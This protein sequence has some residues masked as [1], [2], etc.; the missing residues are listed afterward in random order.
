[1][2]EESL[3]KTNFVGRDG[4]R[5]WIGQVA[6]ETAQGQQI[7]GAGW[8]NRYKVRI[9]G[10]HPYNTSELK[11]EDLPWAQVLLP[12]TSGSGGANQS[13]SVQLSP[14]DSVIGFFLD[15][16]SAQI[17]IIWGVFGR[18]NQVSQNQYQIPFLPYTGQ[19]S[20]TRHDG[21]NLNKGEANESNTKSQK[22]PRNVP[23]SL[24]KKIGKDEISFFSGIG[25]KIYFATQS[26]N[27]TIGKL[28]VEVDN[29]V[30]ALQ[31]GIRKVSDL[32]NVVSDKIQSI[33]TGLVGSM[34]NAIYEKLIPLLNQGLKLLYQ[35]VYNLVLAATGSSTAAHLAGVA[36]QTAMVPP[37][38]AIQKLL[39]CLA[40]SIIN[41]LL[42]TIT[43]LLKSVAKH[44]KRFSSCASNQ[45]AGSLINDIIERIDSG[46]SSVL[47]GVS[48]LLGLIGGFNPATF[49]R[50]AVSS[51][52][53][54]AGL[55]SCNQSATD[56]NKPTN[57]WIIGKGAKDSSGISYKDIMESAN[58]AEALF[59]S[60]GGIVPVAKY[61]AKQIVEGFEIFSNSSKSSNSKCYT[62]PELKCGKPRVKI[63]GGGGSEAEATPLLGAIVSDGRNKTG[64]VVGVKLNKK[65]KKYR[66][67]PFVEIVDECDQ[68][69]GAIARSVLN[70]SGEIDYIY[71]VSE[72]ENYPVEDN[73]PP[74][75]ISDVK[76]VDS[77]SDYT[78]SDYGI[79]QFGNTYKIQVV[80][81][82]IEKVTPNYSETII[83]PVLPNEGEENGGREQTNLPDGT[84][85]DKVFRGEKRRATTVFGQPVFDDIPLITI[86][87]E[88]G[89]GALLSAELDTVPNPQ[90]TKQALNS[91]DCVE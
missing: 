16:D 21:A 12:T 41:G 28:I 88:T 22:S 87:S 79:D 65:G 45:F 58:Q 86:V 76:I 11:N 17:P 18:T 67:P 73:I 1:M 68:G 63:F 62:G 36:A 83:N 85:T 5:W 4:F 84:E 29:F 40:N 52:A 74:Y 24:S 30:N 90:F 56:Y 51:I 15:G 75:Y 3:I 91:I 33:V 64:S 70:E 48:T 66:F 71:M 60:A 47:G 80:N 27:S 14:G 25:D 10:Y 13:E 19:T 32:I 2:I 77:G 31:S 55:L 20:K 26:P 7:N 39:P 42:G 34:A 59:R 43:D 61:G 8:G 50:G 44:M 38:N 23:V 46:M 72:G 49:L 53:G 81:G 37:I 69:Y 6:P 54:V 35:Q 89:F 78:S 57:V 9:M 82:F